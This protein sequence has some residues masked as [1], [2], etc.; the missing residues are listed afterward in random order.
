M[1]RS[2]FKG[3][4]LRTDCLAVTPLSQSAVEAIYGMEGTL[5]KH[6]VDNLCKSHERLRAELSGAMII[7]AE[8]DI[9]GN[10]KKLRDQM[11]SDVGIEPGQRFTVEWLIEIGFVSIRDCAEEKIV[12]LDGNADGEWNLIYSTLTGWELYGRTMP[13]EPTTRDD[14]LKLMYL[15]GCGRR[16]E[17]RGKHPCRTCGVG[18]F[19]NSVCDRCGT[20]QAADD[21]KYRQWLK[22]RETRSE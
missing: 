5:P 1:S 20:S 21:A 16:P 11:V 8:H 12:G 22:S 19:R 18:H 7:L 2:E 17:N 15:T 3:R 14:V 4:R 10:L 9:S 13:V 6:A